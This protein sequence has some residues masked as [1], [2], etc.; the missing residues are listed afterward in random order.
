VGVA[1]TVSLY[2][3][4]LNSE[5]IFKIPCNNIIDPGDQV[6][7]VI[8]QLEAPKSFITSQNLPY[9]CKRLI[10]SVLK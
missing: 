10:R 5:N 2:T 6:V 7:S 4:S 3:I 1:A 8:D 9:I